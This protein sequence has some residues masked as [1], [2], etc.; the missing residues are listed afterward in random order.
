MSNLFSALQGTSTNSSSSDPLAAL[1]GYT[2]NGQAASSPAP[3]TLDQSSPT[4]QLQA[5]IQNL[6]T[7]LDGNGSTGDL[8]GIGGSSNPGLQDLQQSFNSLITA[9]TVHTGCN[10][11]A[12]NFVSMHASPRPCQY[13]KYHADQNAKQEYD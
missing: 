8:L 4:V 12:S 10:L 6:I 1:L 7:Q 9:S 11:A 2:S 5:S 13:R 3:V